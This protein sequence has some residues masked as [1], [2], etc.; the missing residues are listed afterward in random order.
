[1]ATEFRAGGGVLG[2]HVPPAGFGRSRC[3][4]QAPAVTEFPQLGR[5]VPDLA[6]LIDHLDV[7]V[8]HP[9]RT[10]EFS[11]STRYSHDLALTANPL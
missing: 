8:R 7:L 6:L 11:L 5:R 10:P 9:P 2:A 3:P 1:M 4:P